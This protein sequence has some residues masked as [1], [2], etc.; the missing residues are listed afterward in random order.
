LAQLISDLDQRAGLTPYYGKKLPDPIQTVFNT[1]K[2][3]RNFVKVGS[4]LQ[5][6]ALLQSLPLSFWED[7][8]GPDIAKEIAPTGTVDMT[9]LAQI[10]P[11]L[12][13]DLKAALETQLAAY[14]K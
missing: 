14:S 1:D 13:A 11:T 7:T 6:T 2:L 5:N 3:P 12:P 9:M 10:L 8:L 4:A